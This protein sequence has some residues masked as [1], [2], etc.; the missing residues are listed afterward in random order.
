MRHLFFAIDC[1]S[2][3][4]ILSIFAFIIFKIIKFYKQ[5]KQKIELQITNYQKQYEKFIN[6]FENQQPH[7]KRMGYEKPSTRGEIGIA[8]SSEEYNHKEI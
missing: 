3:V 1:F 2:G 4:A 5:R 6:N 8:A 7:R